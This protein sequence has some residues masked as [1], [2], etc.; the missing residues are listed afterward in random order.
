MWYVSEAYANGDGG[1]DVDAEGRTGFPW[2]VLSAL[3]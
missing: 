1:G 2:A 3:R